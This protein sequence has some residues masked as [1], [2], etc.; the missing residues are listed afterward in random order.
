MR[1][2]SVVC[3]V[4]CIALLAVLAGAAFAQQTADQSVILADILKNAGCP[5]TEEQSKKIA[6]LNF[7]AGREAF[8]GLNSMFDEKQTAAL[9]KALGSRE[10]RNGGAE[11]P[12]YLMQLLILERAGCPLTVKQLDALKALPNDRG[13]FMRANDIYTEKQREEIQ[14]VMPRGRRGGGPAGGQTGGQ[15]GGNQ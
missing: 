12:R 9:I 1:K 10:G 7:S 13:S 3:A 2:A 6:G 15:T 11:S 8:Q 4:C 5:L 14:K